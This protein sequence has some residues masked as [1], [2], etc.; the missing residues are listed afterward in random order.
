MPKDRKIHTHEGEE[1]TEVKK[2]A[3]V[4]IGTANVVETDRPKVS[5]GAYQKNVVS[6]CVRLRAQMC[7]ETAREYTIAPHSK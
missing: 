6:G 2:F 7:E 5:Y 3:G 4:F 1:C